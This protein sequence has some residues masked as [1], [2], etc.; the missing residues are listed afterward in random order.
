M[1]KMIWKKGD[2]GRL[3]AQWIITPC[4]PTVR[5]IPSEK[6]LELTNSIRMPSQRTTLL[7]FPKALN[8]NETREAQK[9]EE[10]LP[11]LSAT[12]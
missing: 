1:L 3:Y 12:A 10:P 9:E 6:G 11:P 7:S 5:N 4:A 2:N 8:A